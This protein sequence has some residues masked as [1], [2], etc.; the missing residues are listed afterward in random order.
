MGRRF[1]AAG[2]ASERCSRLT[3]MARVL[4]RCIISRRAAITVHSSSVPPPRL[5]FQKLNNE[6]VLSW[7]NTGFNLQTAPAVTG[8]FT[9]LSGATSPYT[10]V[11]TGVQQFFRL[12]SN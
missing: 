1:T 3:L 2:S 4:R 5:D 6:L 8:T 7:T 9:N 10:N 12:I 11:T